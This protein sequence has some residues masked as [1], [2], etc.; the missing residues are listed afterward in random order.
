[1]VQ[2]FI[3]AEFFR[4]HIFKGRASFRAVKIAVSVSPSLQHVNVLRYQLAA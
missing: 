2:A 3:T 1:M 4:S